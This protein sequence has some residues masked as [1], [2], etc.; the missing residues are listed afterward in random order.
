MGFNLSPDFRP[1][2]SSAVE[3]IIDVND[4]LEFVDDDVIIGVGC[5]LKEPQTQE[6]ERSEVRKTHHRCWRMLLM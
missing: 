2:T 5:A 1:L 4:D 3:S 6:S